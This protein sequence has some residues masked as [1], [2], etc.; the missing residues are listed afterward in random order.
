MAITDAMRNGAAAVRLRTRTL[1][2]GVARWAVVPLALTCATALVLLE[3]VLGLRRRRARPRLVWGPTPIISL[4]YWSA[5]MRGRGYESFTCVTGLYPMHAG[6]EFDHLRADFLGP[7]WLAEL[8]RDYVVFAW[9]LRRGDVFLRF[10]DGGYLRD[11]PLSRLELPLLRLAGKKVVVSPFG[12]DIAVVGHLGELE[13]PLLSDYP[14]IGEQSDRTERQVRH[15]LRWADVVIMN[16]QFGFLP[17]FDVRW[18]TMI[19]IDTDRWRPP[20]THSDGDGRSAEVTVFHAPNH[21]A[22]KGTEHLERAVSELQGEGFRV[23]L[24][25]LEGRPYEEIQAAMRACDIA[26]DQFLAGYAMFAVEGMASGKPVLSNLSSMPAP[27]RST[28]SLREIPI[29]DTD[30]QRLTDDLR[31]LVEQPA[32]R[33]RLGRAGREFVERHHSYESVAD[34]WEAVLSFAWQG[35]PLP[36]DMA[37]AGPPESG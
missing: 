34:G 35:T 4:M 10:F 20:E 31:R 15:T 7:G 19:A 14:H 16:W 23:R 17:S 28:E 21:R 25:I 29:V 32:E 24:K 37:P 18:P 22:I 33:H 36:A 27:V 9:T 2:V 6:D 13:G 1:L 3:R 11:T 12:G 30:P 5:A 26:A 8:V